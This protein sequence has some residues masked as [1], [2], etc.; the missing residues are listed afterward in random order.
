MAYLHIFNPDTDYA[1][2]S[3][4]P[5]FTASAQVASMRLANSLMPAIYASEGDAILIL[6]MIEEEE[7]SRLSHYNIARDKKLSIVRLQDAAR[8]PRILAG[9]AARPWGWNR[10][11]KRILEKKFNGIEG[12]P[13]EERISSLRRLSHRRT[14]IPFLKL[15]DWPSKREMMLPV[16]YFDEEEALDRYRRDKFTYFKAPW[17]SSGRGIL[18]TDDLEER[19]VKPWLHGIISR[20]GSVI[21]EP[22]YIRK[23]DFAT[24]WFCEAGR[25]RFVGLSVFNVSRRG[26]YHSNV[27]ATQDD[28]LRIIRENSSGWDDSIILSQRK[29]IEEIIAPHYAGPLGI[30]MLTD[31]MGRVNPCVEINL[32]FTM[33]LANILKHLL[34]EDMERGESVSPMSIRHLERN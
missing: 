28:L 19:H 7:I 14:T 1:L 2:A 23:L 13:T 12:I 32:R 34:L 24:E 33:G 5:N 6:D 27:D 20:Q 8:N 9:L 3:N 29:A 26:K 16:E 18:L 11:I 10:Q 21:A 15:L 17:S 25:A 4:S 22:A 31:H 30:D